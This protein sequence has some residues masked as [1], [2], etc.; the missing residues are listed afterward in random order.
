MTDWLDK[1]DANFD[2]QAV[3]RRRLGSIIGSCLALAT[4]WPTK[5][6][7]ILIALW[8]GQLFSAR[9]IITPRRR[10]RC[11]LAIEQAINNCQQDWKATRLDTS[12]VVVKCT[13]P[14]P[15][16]RRRWR[17]LLRRYFTIDGS[18]AASLPWEPVP[19]LE[20]KSADTN[21]APICSFGP[22]VWSRSDSTRLMIGDSVSVA[23]IS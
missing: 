19:S 16:D 23:T 2:F 3:V 6:D 13:Q 4:G 7:L 10:R 11:P 12:S 20:R 5:I 1:F 22:S 17:P 9:P 15:I 18:T 8:A 21:Q 14:S